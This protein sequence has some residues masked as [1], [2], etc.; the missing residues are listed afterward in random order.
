MTTHCPTCGCPVRIGGK[1]TT[2]YYVPIQ[3]EAADKL[4]SAAKD[5]MR[6]IPELYGDRM[7]DGRGMF[8]ISGDAIGG[9]DVAISAYEEEKG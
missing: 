7:V 2:K 1:G 5:M 8:S 3:S 9:L 4:L 6:D